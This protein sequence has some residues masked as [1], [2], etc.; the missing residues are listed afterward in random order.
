MTSSSPS[1]FLL[2]CGTAMAF[3]SSILAL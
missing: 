3:Q 1:I 2:T